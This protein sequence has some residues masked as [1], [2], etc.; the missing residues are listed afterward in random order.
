MCLDGRMKHQKP[1]RVG[2]APN[3]KK[4]RRVDW[5]FRRLRHQAV[6]FFAKGDRELR[7]MISDSLE[8][9][10]SY[11]EVERVVT[12]ELRRTGAPTWSQFMDHFFGHRINRRVS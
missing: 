3:G 2:S 12:G 7:K 11:S 6:Q 9:A 4:I 5:A 10:H 8:G 1:G